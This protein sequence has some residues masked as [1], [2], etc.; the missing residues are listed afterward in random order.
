MLN[1]L[2]I[3]ACK[4]LPGNKFVTQ[5]T[6]YADPP[7]GHQSKYVTID[8]NPTYVVQNP[9]QGVYLT[10]AFAVYVEPFE[11]KLNAACSDFCCRQF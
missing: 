8:G 5:E 4:V 7:K 3:V 2:G 10:F 9:D 6:Q 11:S 1:F